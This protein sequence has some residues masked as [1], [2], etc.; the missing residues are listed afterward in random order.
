MSGCRD[1]TAQT[2]TLV[3]VRRRGRPATSGARRSFS[4][5]RPSSASPLCPPSAARRRTRPAR[6]GATAPRW[7]SQ[8][9][10]GRAR[11][12]RRSRRG[13]RAA[14]AR[15]AALRAR[16]RRSLAR[17]RRRRVA[18]QLGIARATM[19]PRRAACSRERL[20]ALYERGEA[21][22]LA[23]V[24]GAESLDDALTAIDGLERTAE[25]DRAII[26]AGARGAQARLA[27]LSASLRSR[28]AELERLVARSRAPRRPRSSARPRERAAY[29]DAPRGGAPPDAARIARLVE[30]A[31]AAAHGPGADA[32]A[33]A[34]AAPAGRR[35]R[36]LARRPPAGRGRAR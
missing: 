33:L 25:H 21:D 27:R 24:L 34:A 29:V 17:E 36:P 18:R 8:D 11:A 6:F 26:G 3:R 31:A 14:Q 5:P 13:S 1:G 12:L 10:L 30:A 7:P 19:R 15:S 35:L 20:R 22:P 9:A 4:S 32:A 2:R 16:D 28:G 23:V